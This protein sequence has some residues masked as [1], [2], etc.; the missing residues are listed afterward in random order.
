MYGNKKELNTTLFLEI[1][2][3]SRKLM[4]MSSLCP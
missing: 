4:G 1:D 3:V 2:K